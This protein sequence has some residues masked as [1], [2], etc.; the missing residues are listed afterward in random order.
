M[1]K[2]EEVKLKVSIPQYFYNIIIPQLGEYYANYPVDFDVKQVV[3]CPL[4]DENT[5]SMRFY[6]ETNTFYCFG[7][8]QGGDVINLHRKFS[9]RI[10]SVRVTFA[11]A[12]DFLYDFFIQGKEN[13]KIVTSPKHL[14]KEKPL[15]SNLDLVKY[16]RYVDLLEQQL[17]VE[18]SISL[19]NKKLIWQAMDDMDVLVDTNS[20]SALEAVEYIKGIVKQSV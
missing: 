18:E 6:P 10:S 3:C 1:N 5:P 4:H 16:C 12:V 7:C 15:N 9:E 11:E 14:I 20:I 17:L 8:R 2:V 19:T 13:S